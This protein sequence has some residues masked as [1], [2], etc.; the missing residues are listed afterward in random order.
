MILAFIMIVQKKVTTSP[1]GVKKTE[2]V[3]DLVLVVPLQVRTIQ[4][5][6]AVYS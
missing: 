1:P 5:N 2:M 6:T 3:T 4:P